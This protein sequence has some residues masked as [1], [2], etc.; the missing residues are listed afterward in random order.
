MPRTSSK[1]VNAQHDCTSCCS[2]RPAEMDLRSTCATNNPSGDAI[3]VRVWLGAGGA[4][5]FRLQVHTLTG[6]A[7]PLGSDDEP[8]FELNIMTGATIRLHGM[9]N[10]GVASYCA[11]LG[12]ALDAQHQ[13]LQLQT[14]DTQLQLQPL[15]PHQN[16]QGHQQQ[17]Q[18][19]GRASHSGGI[20]TACRSLHPCGS[21][22]CGIAP[23]PHLRGAPTVAGSRAD[24]A[25]ASSSALS[26]ER[27]ANPVSRAVGIADGRACSNSC[28]LLSRA[29]AAAAAGTCQCRG[30]ESGA[31]GS[32][33]AV[34]AGTGTGFSEAAPRCHVKD[35]LQV[36]L[37]TA[38]DMDGASAGAAVPCAS[39]CDDDDWTTQPDA[40][41]GPNAVC[42]GC[43]CKKSS[44]RPAVVRVTAWL[45]PSQGN[46]M[47]A[48]TTV[49]EAAAVA[50]EGSMRK[51][52]V[53]AAVAAAAVVV[54][55]PVLAIGPSQELEEVDAVG[56]A[57]ASC[58]GDDDDDMAND[59]DAA[60]QA[61]NN[62]LHW[63][64][65][66]GGGAT[67]RNAHLLE[68]LGLPQ[69]VRSFRMSV[70][71]LVPEPAEPYGPTGQYEERGSVLG[72]LDNAVD[73]AAPHWPCGGPSPC[74]F[75]CDGFLS[76]SA[77]V[78]EMM[79][80]AESYSLVDCAP[81]P[82]D[83][84]ASWSLP[85]M[86]A[87]TS[88]T[89]AC[90]MP[91]SLRRPAATAQQHELQMPL[92]HTAAVEVL[93]LLGSAVD[94]RKG[95]VQCT[96]GF[97]LSSCVGRLDWPADFPPKDL[98]ELDRDGS[99]PQS[100]LSADL[101]ALMFDGDEGDEEKVAVRLPGLK[102]YGRRGAMPYTVDGGDEED[103]QRWFRGGQDAVRPLLLTS[104][105]TGAVWL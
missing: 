37:S 21:S 68:L 23:V 88:S 51:A 18:Q 102:L 90:G 6:S 11:A 100:Q 17:Q 72:L 91:P 55:A 15:A 87:V 30:L 47:A 105:T 69:E 5:L 48:A 28:S 38:D 56:T 104:L 70:S 85:V 32:G 4:S 83:A 78:A 95:A 33:A 58:G 96:G 41:G 14:G 77:P 7:I 61:L 49:A 81:V 67:R 34:A 26:I 75:E 40:V 65:V 92:R 54:P 44:I 43:S 27:A 82:A 52:G 86:A 24:A 74:G 89:A 59:T 9:A 39:R 84:S 29:A 80:G 22:S 71:E 45:R 93:N 97:G 50:E 13:L 31:G 12:Q 16:H 46:D 62:G 53:A 1:H 99:L 98:G 73:A 19:A 101:F 79:T 57:I 3:A 42:S 60:R 20:Q 2:L 64:P 35:W 10:Y 94:P 63:V 36:L 66:G 76:A 8:I 25:A 103:N